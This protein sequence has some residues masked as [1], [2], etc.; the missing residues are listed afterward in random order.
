V[1]GSGSTLARGVS[2]CSE[3]PLTILD[4]LFFRF[5]LDDGWNDLSDEEVPPGVSEAAFRVD[6]LGCGGG[7]LVVRSITSLDAIFLYRFDKRLAL[8]SPIAGLNQ[9]VNGAKCVK[10]AET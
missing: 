6:S 4:A 8:E 10:A 7:E 3:V 2:F 5:F 9:V 1:R